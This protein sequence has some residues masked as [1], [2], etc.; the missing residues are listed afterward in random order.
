MVLRSLFEVKN[1]V[2]V[3]VTV[4]EVVLSS[5]RQALISRIRWVAENFDESGRCNTD[6]EDAR[7]VASLKLLHGSI[8]AAPHSVVV[9]RPLGA[10]PD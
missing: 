6:L 4:L 1:A 9:Q 5:T 3:E 7:S 2:A 8:M 10:V